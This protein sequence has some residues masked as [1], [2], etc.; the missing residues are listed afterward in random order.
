MIRR[1]KKGG[2]SGSG[3]NLSAS[4]VASFRTRTAQIC[5]SA[6]HCLRG[7]AYGNLWL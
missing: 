4:V 3:C 6:S 2:S 7:S 5:V 1:P